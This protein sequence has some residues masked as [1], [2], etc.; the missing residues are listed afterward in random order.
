ML[1]RPDREAGLGA[2]GV[3][4]QVVGQLGHEQDGVVGADR[5]LAGVGLGAGSRVRCQPSSVACGS[6]SKVSLAPSSST[7]RCP[8]GRKSRSAVSSVVL[9]APPAWAATMSGTRPSIS[10]QRVAAS[11]ASSVPARISSDDGARRRR[12][13]ADGPPAPRGRGVGQGNLR[14]IHCFPVRGGQRTAD[15]LERQ[16]VR[17]VPAPRVVR[18]LGLLPR[19]V[20]DRAYHRRHGTPDRAAHP[21]AHPRPR[22]ALRP[23]WRPEV[24]LVRLVPGPRP[25]LV[26]RHGRREPQGPPDGGEGTGQ[27]AGTRRVRGRHGGR[28]G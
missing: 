18:R 13:V 27:R 28:A 12:H 23:G 3:R 24:V 7:I 25:G 2:P 19:T 22:H 5:R 8:G 9:P 16:T 14:T 26:E 4:R 10:S 20:T 11:S 15:P 21:R 17:C 6:Q 1:D